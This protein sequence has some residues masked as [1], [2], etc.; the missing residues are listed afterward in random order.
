[1][2]TY[3]ESLGLSREH[4]MKVATGFAGGMRMGE[5]CGAVT[6]ALMTLGLRYA[7]A[8]SETRGSRDKIYASVR[9]FVSRFKARNGSVVCK[10][11]LGCDLSTPAGMAII[12]EQDL[13][14]IICS[15]LVQD[16]AEILEEML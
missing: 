8:D 1:M 16:A 6:G 2:A 11:L 7:G 4:A 13:F 5:T 10:D 3:G 12:Q 9:D 15:K 14:N